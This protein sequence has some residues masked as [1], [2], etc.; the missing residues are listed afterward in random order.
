MLKKIADR[1]TVVETWV[2]PDRY[3]KTT[4][5]EVRT[6]ASMLRVLAHVQ[7]SIQDRKLTSCIKAFVEWHEAE[8][9]GKA[10]DPKLVF[11]K[12]MRQEQGLSDSIPKKFDQTL[13]D[14][15]MYRDPN[16][17][18]EALQILLLYK[19]QDELL[20]QSLRSLQIIYTPK[21]EMKYKCINQWLK[22]LQRLAEAFEMWSDMAMPEELQ[23]AI[24][25]CDAIASIADLVRVRTVLKDFDLNPIS[26]VDTEVQQLLKN[27]DAM[28]VF[29]TLQQAL[30]DAS[31][32]EPHPQVKKIVTAC[33]DL[34]AIFVEN[35]EDNQA[36][37]FKHIDW[38][39]D[40]VDDGIHSSKVARFVLSGNRYL[41]KQCQRRYLAEF[42]QKIV[43]NG[44]KPEYLDMFVGMT[45]INDTGDSGVSALHSEI[46]R[47]VTNVE[48]ADHVLLWCC[49]PK[50]KGYQERL[51]VM[52]DFV[53]LPKPVPDDELPGDLQYHINLLSLLAGCKLGPKLQ[54]VYPLDDV[55]AGILD[56]GTISNVRNGLVLLLVEMVTARVDGM[57]ASESVWKF[58]EFV[59]QS[60]RN[61][62]TELP[63]LLH[64]SENHLKLTHCKDWMASCLKIISMFFADFDFEEFHDFT[65]FDS[66]D[67]FSV[68]TRRSEV[69]VREVINEMF[70]TIKKFR[71][72]H[73][74]SLSKVSKV[75][76]EDALVS[77]SD[78]SD[79]SHVD[80]SFTIKDRRKSHA[81]ARRAS[82][83]A[84]IQQVFYRKQ[85]GIFVDAIA[86][87]S[88]ETTTLSHAVDPLS[89]ELLERMPSVYDPVQSDV[90]L[91]PFFL[92]LTTHLRGQLVRTTSARMLDKSSMETSV[93]VMRTLRH[94]I[95]KNI[96]T[97]VE[98]ISNPRVVA[99]VFDITYF[100]SVMDDYGVTY[101]C[102]DLISVGIDTKLCV[103]AVKLLAALLTRHGGNP[104][105]QRTIH[106]YLSSTDSTLFFE[107]IKDLIE[108]LQVW[109]QRETEL[110]HDAEVTQSA[111]LPPEVYVLQLIYA[112]CDGNFLPNKHIMRNQEGNSRF[113]NILDSLTGFIDLLS[114]LEGAMCTQVAV[115]VMHTILGLLRGPC[116]GSQEHF[117]LHTELLTALNRLMRSARPSINFSPAWKEDVDI[118]KEYVIDVMRACIEGLPEGSVVVERVQTAIEVNV[119]NVL[120]IPNEVDEFGISIDLSH[121]SGLQAKYLVFLK[122]LNDKNAEMPSNAV[123]CVREDITSVEVVW[124]Q[125]LYQHHFHVPD[126]AKDLSEVSKR[127]LVEEVDYLT[128][129]IKLKDFIKKARELHREGAHQQTLKS[130]GLV[131]LWAWKG[132]LAKLLLIN[133]I[134]MNIL[135]TM[136]FTVQPNTDNN[137]QHHIFRIDHEESFN[138]RNSSSDH[139]EHSSTS[140][141]PY[142]IYLPTDTYKVIHSLNGLHIAVVMVTLSIILVVRVPLAY[143]SHRDSGQSW[144]G[145]MCLTIFTPSFLWYIAHTTIAWIAFLINPLYLSPLLLE[146]ISV[147][148]ATKEIMLAVVNPRRQLLTTMAIILIA[149][150][151]FASVVFVFFRDE[152]LNLVCN[153]MWKSLKLMISYGFR[154]EEGIGRYMHDTIGI[155]IIMD[156][157]FY[158]VIVV[159]LRNI[160]FGII[161]DTFGE[162]RSIRM[163]RELDLNGK[164]FVCGINQQE[165]DK[166]I[167]YG[168][169]IDFRHHR[170]VT[171]NMW[172]Y[173]Y[174]VMRIWQQPR[175]HDNSL[176]M[177]VRQ[178]IES[179][180]VSWFPIG[181]IGMNERIDDDDKKESVVEGDDSM[182][183]DGITSK[184]AQRRRT[185]VVVDD[186]GL[187][188]LDSRLNLIQ[189]RLCHLQSTPPVEPV[190]RVSPHDIDEDMVQMIEKV[191]QAEIEPLH[192]ALEEVMDDVNTL[193]GRLQ[194]LDVT[195]KR[196]RLV[197]Q[198]SQKIGAMSG[199]TLDLL[200]TT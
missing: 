80:F 136:H 34:I 48:R 30:L 67:H 20:F 12:Y 18:K 62:L 27:L 126:V 31:L 33:N 112:M 173:L 162:L 114:K 179:N 193:Y 64:K 41:I 6:I 199:P 122:S 108:Q 4:E 109:C 139:L 52:A 178:C 98:R 198:P 54:A 167:G 180:D 58:F 133:V 164:C 26:F 103:E 65:S 106:H 10:I 39:L 137:F 17:V 152:F 120:I 155:R 146:F 99:E 148:S 87:T 95:E 196:R 156:V 119:L 91:E 50:S 77:W 185:S 53:K 130:V 189:E 84:E 160:F 44:R 57:V 151:I 74:S 154:S 11:N 35:N 191:V 195:S 187:G 90:R 23:V 118:L 83:V 82:I 141:S 147:D 140:A 25:A 59:T 66:D 76:F 134:I 78:F 123:E 192:A 124:N 51:K 132:I 97:T 1:T 47:Y 168:S 116:R 142:D 125:K 71:D 184:S 22:Q 32:G 63:L 5:N 104:S 182:P 135:M 101:L 157:S 21:M 14:I 117:V 79:E 56:E 165:F 45:Q 88:T 163:D 43:T 49:G 131:H 7:G 111:Y 161:I 100:H 3:S 129:E 138:R 183:L 75:M 85:F 174:F 144:L 150:H 37:A 72:R 60:F 107:E 186:V 36:I 42:M 8:S 40:R 128:Q 175:S 13:I 93:W 169:G 166:R 86:P 96:G 61:F 188:M 38:F 73:I 29:M 81:S 177:Y 9:V 16:L 115:R 172:N 200:D 159:I 24:S 113:V 194:K 105:M 190:R 46:A 55:V 143:A 153:S 15:A 94:I 2:I 69:E 28:S 19:S 70:R 68:I 171:H 197:S 181:L 145:A 92:K 176:E 89:L 110:L 121:L 170:T 127:K 102:L 149:I 158:F